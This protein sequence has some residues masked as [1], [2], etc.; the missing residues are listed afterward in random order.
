VVSGSPTIAGAEGSEAVVLAGAHGSKAVACGDDGAGGR[1]L[2]RREEE[3]QAEGVLQGALEAGSAAGRDAPPSR[4]PREAAE[5]RRVDRGSH[6]QAAAES[7]ETCEIRESRESQ[8][9][10]ES[11]APL[12]FRV[13]LSGGLRGN[14]LTRFP[15]GWT[16]KRKARDFDVRLDGLFGSLDQFLPRDVREE[17]VLGLEE[18]LKL[19]GHWWQRMANPEARITARRPLGEIHP[20]LR[21]TYIELVD[22]GFPEDEASRRMRW[23]EEGLLETGRIPTRDVFAGIVAARRTLHEDGPMLLGLGQVP[24]PRSTSSGRPDE[25]GSAA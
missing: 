10:A 20:L 18:E 1:S 24:L 22:V 17:I 5:T 12:P 14:L 16:K 6:P 2:P 11:G 9:T 13:P 8:E 21:E 3:A 4:G 25:F 7:R 19:S 23:L 15:P